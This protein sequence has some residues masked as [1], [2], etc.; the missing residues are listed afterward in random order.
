MCQ[1]R[2][3]SWNI[4]VLLRMCYIFEKST[5][6]LYLDAH[7]KDAVVIQDTP[8]LRYTPTS[9]CTWNFWRYLT[10]LK[11][12]RYRKQFPTVSYQIFSPSFL[13]PENS[14]LCSKLLALENGS[15]GRTD[16]LLF[17]DGFRNATID[18]WNLLNSEWV[19][20]TETPQRS[21]SD[22]SEDSF[23]FEPI[24]AS[25]FEIDFFKDYWK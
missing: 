4:T 22:V 21:L 10:L 16:C 20:T 25:A 15:S 2:A 13:N 11:M 17:H 9:K 12:G 8:C 14:W 18:S 3:P 5:R 23:G 24:P 1:N 6:V 7:V 19:S